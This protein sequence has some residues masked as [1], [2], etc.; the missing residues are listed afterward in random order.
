MKLFALIVL[1]LFGLN[2]IL[3]K[4][5]RQLAEPCEAS[6]VVLSFRCSLIK[7]ADYMESQF[8][9][10]PSLSLVNRA[11]IVWRLHGNIQ[12]GCTQNLCP[13]QNNEGSKLTIWLYQ[14]PPQ[15][16]FCLHCTWVRLCVAFRKQSDGNKTV[17]VHLTIC[18][19]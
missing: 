5:Y 2:G 16:F 14:W 1:L 19:L 17:Q 4:F 13:G 10:G 6:A 7:G 11:G 3:G 9:P 15:I 12:P 8:Q 18:L